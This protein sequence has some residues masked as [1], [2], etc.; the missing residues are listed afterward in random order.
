[1]GPYE[2]ALKAVNFESMNY[3]P[4]VFWANGQNY[5]PMAGILDN[6]YYAD[7]AKML[8]AQLHFY[9]LFPGVFTVPGIWP[10][11]GAMAEL[12]GLGCEIEFPVN[13]PPYMRKSVLKNIWGIDELKLP[14]PRQA[15]FTAR[16]LDYLKYFQQHLP[17]K[18]KKEYGFLDGHLFCGGPGE[19]SA[20]LLGYDQIS[21]AM[22]DTPELVHRLLRKVTDFVKSY[23]QAQM[24]VVGPAKRVC[25]WD[26]FPGMLPRDLYFKFIHPYL[27]EIFAFVDR[28][29]IKVYH[30]ENNYPHLMDLVREIR[31]N[32]CQLG[33]KHDLVASKKELGKCVMGN[34]HPLEILLKGSR[35]EIRACC[36]RIIQEAGPGGGLWLSAA[37][38]LAPETP[39][40]NIKIMIEV[41]RETPVPPG[42][43]SGK[44]KLIQ[45]GS[46]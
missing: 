46:L 15:E 9:E 35:E 16:V 44:I 18:M 3:V 4:V 33:P 30:N 29:E 45:K 22:Y 11:F 37:G 25:I 20:L 27:K 24:E 34:V 14:D 19:I 21:Y 7:P 40:E 13:A 41:A 23:L 8:E 28:A 1:M 10:D 43:V 26:H 17:E 42:S 36:Q 5:A 39:V 38:G 31:A 32:I 12:G 2:E 6:E